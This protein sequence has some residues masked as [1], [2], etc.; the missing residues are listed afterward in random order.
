LDSLHSGLFKK[1]FTILSVA[2]ASAPA[3]HAAGIREYFYR[4]PDN[5]FNGSRQVVDESEKAA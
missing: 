3:N 5:Q 4:A 1:L 2:G